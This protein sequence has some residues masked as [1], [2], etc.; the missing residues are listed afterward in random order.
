M[1]SKEEEDEEEGSFEVTIAEAPERG[2]LRFARCFTL[3]DP[4][5]VLISSRKEGGE[6]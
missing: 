6:K 3:R 4:T 2:L 1:R 5:L